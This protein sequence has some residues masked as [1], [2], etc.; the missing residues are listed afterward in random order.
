M[1]GTLFEVGTYQI[2]TLYFQ[3]VVSLFL[4]QKRNNNKTS[5]C[6]DNNNNNNNNNN[7]DNKNGK[8]KKRNT[9]IERLNY[10]KV[11]IPNRLPI[12]K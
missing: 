4:Q 12:K 3:Q 10:I 2:F 11:N 6:N 9:F 7:N 8:K 1:G 5:R